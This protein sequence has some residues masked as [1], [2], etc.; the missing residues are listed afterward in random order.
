MDRESVAQVSDT[1]PQK[2]SSTLATIFRYVAIG[3]GIAGIGILVAVGGFLLGQRNDVSQKQTSEIVPTVS[4]TITLAPTSAVDEAATI[5]MAIKNALIAEHGSQAS[6]LNVT[7]SKVE[8]D[9]ASGAASEQGGGGMWF[10]ARVGGVWQLVTDGNGI[11]LCSSLSAYPNFP[12]K[13]IPECFD[14]KTQNIV[15]R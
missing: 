12:T 4:V 10:A 14:D 6:S 3:T 15:K 13:M 7:V 8:G 2:T 11:T 5:I 9:F 1:T